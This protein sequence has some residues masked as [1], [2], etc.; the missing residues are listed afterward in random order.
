M[1][2]RVSWNPV[3][4]LQHPGG[5]RVPAAGGRPPAYFQQA[6]RQPLP[7]VPQCKQAVQN[8]IF[9]QYFS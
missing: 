3:L 6:P 4:G 9:Y 8:Y 2:A 7:R 1:Q 5:A